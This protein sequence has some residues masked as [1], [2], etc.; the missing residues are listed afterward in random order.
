MDD[1][2]LTRED[3]DEKWKTALHAEIIT[4]LTGNAT[5]KGLA[6]N[7]VGYYYQCCAPAYL[8]KYYKPTPT[9]IETIKSNRMWYS[10]PCNFNDVFDCDIHIDKDK[11]LH[12]LSKSLGSDKKHVRP[13]SPVWRD[14]MKCMRQLQSNLDSLKETTGIACLSESNDS[15]L[16]W[17]HYADNHSGICVQYALLDINTQLG[18]SPIPVIYSK[19]KLCVD[20]L[21]LEAIGVDVYKI[22]IGS[23]TTKSLEW[24]YEQEWRI[25]R[26]NIAC[27]DRW[28]AKKKGALLD[29]ICPTSII[30]GCQADE[31]TRRVFEEYCKACNVNLYKMKK[32]DSQYRLNKEIVLEFDSN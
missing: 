29:M 8:Y 12:S 30:L 1:L 6:E 28:D 17:A 25:I 22:L 26:D 13:G 21:N 20:S 19:D 24:S 2:T 23:T 7:E 27:G 32:D 4:A 18:F 5:E 14:Q 10:A 9:N 3:N 15:L 16:M 11:T 31:E